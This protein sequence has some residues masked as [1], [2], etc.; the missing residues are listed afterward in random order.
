MQES[1]TTQMSPPIQ[2][3]AALF[4][5]G[6]LLIAIT[7][8]LARRGLLTIRFT[9]GWMLLGLIVIVASVFTSALPTVGRLFGMSPTG[10]LLS[11]A[12]I[13]LLSISV[14]L[15]ISISVLQVKLMKIVQEH[16]LSDSSV[17]PNDQ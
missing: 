4:L 8:L 15:S 12:S 11:L 16:A 5:G 17:A 13:I 6:I 10:F 2:Q 1:E 9:L 14:Q 3:A 7:G